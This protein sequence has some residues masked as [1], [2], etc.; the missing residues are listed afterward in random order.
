MIFGNI[1]NLVTDRR[2]LPAALTRGVEY[3]RDTDFPR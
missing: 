3:L 1:R 2:V